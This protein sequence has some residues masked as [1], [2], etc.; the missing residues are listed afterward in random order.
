MSEIGL[1]SYSMTGSGSEIQDLRKTVAKLR[2]PDGCPWDREQTHQSLADCL[3]EEC[4]ELLDTI[5]RDDIEHMKE[6][7]GDVLLQVVMH[8]QLA[9]EE[10][11][12]DLEAVTKQVNEKLI[13]RHPH[14]FGS[15]KAANAEDALHRWDEIKAGEKGGGIDYQ[16]KLEKLPPQLPALLYA[17]DVYKLIQKGES[18]WYDIVD[19]EVVNEISDKIDEEEAGKR[20][21][22][23]A[24]ACR[25]A[26]ID[27]ESAL[28]RYTSKLVRNLA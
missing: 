28:R 5:D 21:F 15:R 1:H 27:P 4:A 23:F 11:A 14:V 20:L 26:N 9:E 8:A 25:E 24:A 7:L 12:F 13:R 18:N 19:V 22:E 16:G 6:E 2:A 10:S 17:R 3:M